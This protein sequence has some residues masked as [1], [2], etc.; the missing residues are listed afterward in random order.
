MNVG[1]SVV[2]ESHD[3]QLSEVKRYLEDVFTIRIYSSLP[4]RIFFP[5]LSTQLH[6]QPPFQDLKK[7]IQALHAVYTTCIVWLYGILINDV[8]K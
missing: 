7:K 2:V 6:F 1:R 3:R 4:N 5:I 8:F